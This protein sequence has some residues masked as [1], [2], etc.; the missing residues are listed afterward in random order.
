MKKYILR[1]DN[2]YLAVSRQLA[3]VGV[4]DVSKATRFNS[5]EEAGRAAAGRAGVWEPIEVPQP[6]CPYEHSTV[7]C[8]KCGWSPNAKIPHPMN[9]PSISMAD[10]QHVRHFLRS[11]RPGHVI[12][13]DEEHTDGT[14]VTAAHANVTDL[15]PGMQKNCIEQGIIDPPAEKRY[16]IGIR[17]ARGDIFFWLQGAS[18]G[19]RFVWDPDPKN[20]LFFGSEKVA[21]DYMSNNHRHFWVYDENLT[22]WELPA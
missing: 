8:N 10:E 6:L 2:E 15:S 19:D 12:V 3:A 5:I 17:S 18:M 9:T 14:T 21:K 22:I 4:S 7:L 1:C 11:G 16:G 13:V 20:A